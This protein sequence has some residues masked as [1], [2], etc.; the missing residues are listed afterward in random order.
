MDVTAVTYEPH[1]GDFYTLNVHKIDLATGGKRD[2][3]STKYKPLTKSQ[4]ELRD[5]VSSAIGLFQTK[6]KIGARESARLERCLA[7]L[8]MLLVQEE[9]AS[10]GKTILIQGPL[11]PKLLGRIGYRYPRRDLTIAFVSIDE[12]SSEDNSIVLKLGPQDWDG[13]FPWYEEE[14]IT[15]TYFSKRGNVRVDLFAQGLGRYPLD[16]YDADGYAIGV[17]AKLAANSQNFLAFAKYL[18]QIRHGMQLAW[19]LDVTKNEID[20]AARNDAWKEDGKVTPPP[21]STSAAREQDGK[22]TTPPNSPGAA[23]VSGRNTN[24]E[25]VPSG[26]EEAIFQGISSVSLNT[27]IGQQRYDKIQQFLKHDGLGSLLKNV[28]FLKF[29]EVKIKEKKIKKTIVY[30]IEDLRRWYSEFQHGNMP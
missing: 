6:S 22:V 9:L 24:L 8:L 21:D 7:D 25:S 14:R 17:R 11:F 20:E 4:E 12:V 23:R 16:F 30:S 27:E 3:L 15:R 26:V 18:N 13:P 28:D 5:D 10:K 2:A 29:V 1:F 19:P